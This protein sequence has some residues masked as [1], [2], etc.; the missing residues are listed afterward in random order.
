MSNLL[1]VRARIYCNLGDVI[2]GTIED[3][4]L[5]DAGLVPTTG[6]LVLDGMYAID[7]N[8]PVDLAYYKNGVMARLGK[9][10]RVITSY[11]NPV[12]NTTEVTIGCLLAVNAD[13]SPGPDRIL[14]ATRDPYRPQLGAYW[15]PN[16]KI[17][18]QIRAKYI[19]EE[20]LRALDIKFDFIPLTNV[21]TRETFS[22][23]DSYLQVVSDLLKSE[24]YVGYMDNEERLRCLI[25]SNQTG[26]GPLFDENNVIDIRAISPDGRYYK[27]VKTPYAVVAP[28]NIQLPTRT[29]A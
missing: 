10:L 12:T 20:Y 2:S 16:V 3:A 5:I 24:C 15:G 22:T 27:E 6:R 1:D 18:K 11:A 17:P 4:S 26:M 29:R 13:V 28:K 9:R 21:F 7:V 25:L 14:M 23:E 19:V 8:E